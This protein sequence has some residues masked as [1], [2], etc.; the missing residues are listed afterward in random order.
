MQIGQITKALEN[1]APL[2]FQEDYDNCGLL[3]GSPETICTG[4]LCSLDCTEA[5]IEEA[6]AKGCNLIV[7][8]HPIIF[9]GIKQFDES[10]YVARTVL[11]AIQNNIALYAIHTNLDNILDGVNKTLA[12]RLNLENRQILAPKPGIKDQKG[13]E[14]GAGIIGDL[15]NEMET[16]EFLKWIKEILNIELIKHTPFT[17][18]LLKTIAL[19]GGA[20]SFL[21]G[22][23]KAQKADCYLTGD[24][25]YHDY[26]EADGRLL[27]LDIGH[28]E[29]EQW[30]PALIV[31]HLT[32]KFPTFAVLQ[33]LVCT[34]PITYF[35]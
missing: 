29:S 21:I 28:G 14:I 7:S 6:I 18:K 34:Q 20:G 4:V 9:K 26:F 2:S 32:G 30:V 31:A 5:V 19:C 35:K 33:S 3:V 15:P 13:Q 23:A 22:D 12:D 25:K 17:G 24:L 16:A 11:K 10:S 27:L 8:H 1:W